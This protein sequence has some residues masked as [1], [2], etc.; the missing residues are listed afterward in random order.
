M[1]SKGFTIVELLI[2]AGIFSLLIVGMTLA[3]VQ[4]QRQYNLTQDV[5]DVDHTARAAL[6][7][8]ASEIRNAGSRQGKTFS[9]GFENGGSGVAP[10]CDHNTT[11]TG[12]DSPPDCLTVYTWD[13]T[14]GRDGDDMPSLPGSVSI[15]SEGPPLVLN[16]PSEWFFVGGNPS[17]PRNPPLIQD[18]DLLGARSRFNLCYPIPDPPPPIVN[19]NSEPEKCTECSVILRVD[20]NDQDQAVV[21]DASDIIEQNFQEADFANLSVFIT[22]FFRP[23]LALQSSEITIVDMKSFRVDLTDRELEM[24]QSL[25][26]DGEPGNFQPIAGGRDAP[27]IVDLQLVF[28]IQGLDGVI[29]KVGVP[30]DPPNRKFANFDELDDWI[31]AHPPPDLLGRVGSVNDIRSVEIYLVVRSQT[32]PRKITG[33]LFA[34]DISAI[35]DVDEKDLSDNFPD[36]VEGFIYRVFSTTVYVRNLAREEF[37]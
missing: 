9:I 35:G 3:L 31:A 8:I 13:I 25:D 34:Q 12:I 10:Q 36:P 29:T 23:M 37:G 20:I 26:A 17:E 33:G 11:E 1:N 27:G 30:S 6:D 7:Y 24:S 28:N 14:E 19:C 18:G 16:L 5:V 22:S 4:Q 2:S 15:S 21:D 32:R